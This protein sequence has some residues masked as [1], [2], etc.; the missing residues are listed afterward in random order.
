MQVAQKLK[1]ATRGFIN[2]SRVIVKAYGELL[3]VACNDTAAGRA[4]NRR[5][6][7]WTVKPHLWPI[8]PIQSSS[9]DNKITLNTS[10][11]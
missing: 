2:P 1:A 4:R 10:S 3:P 8:Q 6:E 7:I 11:E 5:V 9:D